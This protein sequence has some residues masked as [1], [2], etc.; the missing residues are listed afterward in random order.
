MLASVPTNLI[1]PG[2]R[3]RPTSEEQVASLV[4]SIKDVGLLNPITVYPRKV[5]RDGIAVDGYGLIAGMHRLDACKRLGLPDI[6]A[7]VVEM[8]ELERQIAECDENLCASSLSPAERALFTARRKE[9]YEA[10]HPETK[11]GAI[12][13]AGMNAALGRD[14]GDNL[15]PTF[16]ADTA[17]RTGASERTIQRDATRGE[18]IDPPALG[19]IRGTALDTGA[20][21]DQL[22][23]I[24]RE[25]QVAFV[26]RKLEAATAPKPKSAPRPAP[27]SDDEVVEAE[28]E[29]FVKLWNKLSP[30]ARDRCFD[31]LRHDGALRVA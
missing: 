28:V 14:V 12:R 10:L 30:E 1:E 27:V 8:G 21:L 16:T 11:A 22:R 29:R 15:A 24:K 9:A 7:N 6:A 17:A 26:E 3:L 18:E 4:A 19:L 20:F 13:A 2:R 5:I 31:W 25:N 23:K